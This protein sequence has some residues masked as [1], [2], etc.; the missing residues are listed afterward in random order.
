L[1]SSF[2]SGYDD[3][4]LVIV[5]TGDGVGHAATLI[6]VSGSTVVYQDNQN[7]GCLRTCNASDVIRTYK[8]EGAR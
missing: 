6:G 3:S 2:V 1:P 8:V 4:T 5:N 7:G